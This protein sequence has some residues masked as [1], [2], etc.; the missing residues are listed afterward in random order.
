MNLKQSWIPKSKAE[1]YAQ[2]AVDLMKLAKITVDEFFEIPVGAREDMVQDLV[3]GL[4][5]IF[6]EYTAFVAS[7]GK[8]SV[9]PYKAINVNL[10]CN[11]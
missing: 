4:E 8:S 1:P 9:L 2:S 3:E 11:H 6:H 10:T 7:C 5:S